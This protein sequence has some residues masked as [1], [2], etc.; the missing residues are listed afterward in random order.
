MLSY[1]KLCESWQL[2]QIY[3]QFCIPEF[4]IYSSRRYFKS[5]LT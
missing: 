4:Q 3:E 2:T 1:K 5:C